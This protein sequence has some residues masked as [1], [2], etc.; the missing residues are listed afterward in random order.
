MSSLVIEN[1]DPSIDFD[2]SK[3]AGR[4][5]TGSGQKI[6]WRQCFIW[7]YTGANV[8]EPVKKHKTRD[9][10]ATIPHGVEVYIGGKEGVLKP[11]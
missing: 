5:L 10:Q 11:L 9:G 3:S 6:A 4:W 2:D 8:D 7:E 1:L